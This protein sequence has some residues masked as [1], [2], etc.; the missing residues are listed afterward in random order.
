MIKAQELRIGNFIL[1]EIYPDLP[2]WHK[3]IPKDIF[4]ISEGKIT[5]NSINPISLTPEILGKCGFKKD[6]TGFSLVDKMSLS[7]SITKD[8]EFLA[9]WLDMSLAITIKYLHELQNLY[10]CLIAEELNINL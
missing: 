7:F 8:A 9:C 6:Y 1:L 4:D 3:I 10:R 2:R 5:L